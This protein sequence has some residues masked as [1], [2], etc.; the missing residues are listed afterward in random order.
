M[1][2]YGVLYSP[3]PPLLCV[4]VYCAEDSILP[5]ESV[6][7]EQRV[8]CRVG[9]GFIFRNSVGDAIGCGTLT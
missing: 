2:V 8:G 6:F 5:T 4:C 7:Q 9:Q 1:L 3:D